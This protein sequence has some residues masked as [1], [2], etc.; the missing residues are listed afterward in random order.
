[1]PFAPFPQV[2]EVGDRAGKEYG[3]E[4]TLNKMKAA[5]ICTYLHT[6]PARSLPSRSH[7]SIAWTFCEAD[8]EPLQF[9]LSE[10][11]RPAPDKTPSSCV[12]T[13]L[14]GVKEDGHIC[15]QGRRGG[16]ACGSQ[17]LGP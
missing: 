17:I 5:S 7:M 16:P 3:L 13:D 14:G 9:D 1:M 10:K 8:W 4:K 11:Y 12:C 6:K 2:A 15:P